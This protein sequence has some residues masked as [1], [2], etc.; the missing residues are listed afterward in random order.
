MEH[1]L[2]TAL[3]QGQLSLQDWVF[4]CMFELWGQFLLQDAIIFQS[5]LTLTVSLSHWPL[6][7]IM[8]LLR[9]A[10]KGCAMLNCNLL[11]WESLSSK[12]P[13]HTCC[14]QNPAPSSREREH[15]E[16]KNRAQAIALRAFLP[17]L[18]TSVH[19]SF[20][21]Q[22]PQQHNGSGLEGES[23]S[24]WPHWSAPERVSTQASVS[25]SPRLL[26]NFLQMDYCE[27]GPVHTHRPPALQSS[28][29]TKAQPPKHSASSQKLAWSTAPLYGPNSP[30]NPPQPSFL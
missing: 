18:V 26:E 4:G 25:C 20:W 13:L 29:R 23:I 2:M 8:I 17:I 6:E 21:K 10:G 16:R 27:W 14:F 5:S 7:K 1:K 24:C 11:A 22:I 15:P 28:H 30:T 3:C 9:L 19:R 12:H